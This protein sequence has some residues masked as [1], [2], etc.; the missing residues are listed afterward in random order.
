VVSSQL[1]P[2][3]VWIPMAGTKVESHATMG[4]GS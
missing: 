2:S 3:I 1:D 4:N